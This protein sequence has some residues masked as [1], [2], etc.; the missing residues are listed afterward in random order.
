MLATAHTFVLEGAMGHLIEVQV[1]ISPGVVGATIVG[2]PD[3]SLLEARDRVR[4]AVTH[5][6]PPWPT[7]RRVTILLAPADLPKRGTHF[8]L[9]IA[10]GV[11]A[12][13]GAVPRDELAGTVFLGELGLD[14]RLRPVGGVLPMVMAAARRGFRR[15][16]V[17]EPQAREAAMV[18]GVEVFGVR[19][20]AQVVAQL[21]GDVVPE[22]APVTAPSG[23]QLLSWRGEDRRDELD[24][25]DLVGML[26]AKYAVEVAAAGGHHLLLS[27]PKGAGKTSLAERIPGIL[28]D[29]T[30]E[31]ALELTAVRSL[32]GPLG[33]VDE[34][35][36]LTTRPPFQAPHHDASKASILGGGSGRVRPGELSRA[37]CGVLFLD[38]FP[39]FRSDVIDGLR[40]PL[41]SGEIRVVRGE[42]AA[43]FPARGMVV[44]AANPCPCGEYHPVA[45][46]NRCDCAEVARRDYRRKVSGPVTD[47]IDI[48]RHVEPARGHDGD[49][50]EA[51][52]SSE[53]VR[54]RVAAARARQ[55]TRYS[56]SGWRLNSQVPGHELTLHWPLPEVGRR[57]LD[58]HLY[59]GAISSRG[60]VRIHRLAWT[61]A[62]L[63]GLDAPGLD[64]VETALALRTGDPLPA[65]ALTGGVR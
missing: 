7:T 59:S 16:F 60:A 43:V 32:A 48:V 49:R 44:L 25:I 18:P 34:R 61:V 8:D 14:G 13:D 21:R 64:E 17:P 62:D 11:K 65:R 42:E 27:G 63:R 41:E 54:T 5:D 1:D 26:E 39:L 15:V 58:D 24:M 19:S 12:A 9:A 23:R 28:P 2:R 46:K 4:M 20:L 52:D 38:E 40:Q 56:G 57:R 45:G 3:A 55:A 22:A 35:W 51:R 6:A 10:L 53:Q 29:L 50:F 30:R 36:E 47:R 33:P 31:E 37:H